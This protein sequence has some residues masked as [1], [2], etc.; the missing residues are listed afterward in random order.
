MSACITSAR[1]TS[2]VRRSP[3]CST[4][5]R[6]D[7]CRGTRCRLPTIGSTLTGCGSITSPAGTAS[8]TPCSARF[9]ASNAPSIDTST[10]LPAACARFRCITRRS[11]YPHP[12]EAAWRQPASALHAVRTADHRR[13]PGRHRREPRAR[14]GAD[15]AVGRRRRAWRSQDSP[16]RSIARRAVS[17][18]AHGPAR[19]ASRD[20]R[21]A[22]P[23]RNLFLTGQDVSTCALPA[24]LRE[25]WRRRPR[26][27][28]ATCSARLPAPNGR[29][30][31][32][33]AAARKLP[34]SRVE[35]GVPYAFFAN[36]GTWPCN[37]HTITW[38]R[39]R[40][41]SKNSRCA[42]NSTIPAA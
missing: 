20:L 38:V 17:R 2:R 7:G 22:T 10:R 33:G 11:W 29:S 24:R 12:G 13:S 6:K 16:H 21:P 3:R 25:R 1:F 34:E 23:I 5:L 31:S 4:T 30:P 15:G 37:V 39:C 27:S 32:P 35:R 9:R 42:R 19:F 40:R 26:F 36:Q 18:L 28:A 14:G 8:A 41:H